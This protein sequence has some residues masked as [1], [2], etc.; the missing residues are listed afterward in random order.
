MMAVSARS[1][2][3][4]RKLAHLRGHRFG[5][6][7]SRFR[8]L[9]DA[10][11]IVQILPQDF[12]SI[13]ALPDWIVA[14]GDR[15]EQIGVAAAILQARDAIERELS[16]SR[17]AAIA[18]L[19]GDDLFERLCDAPLPEDIF[20]ASAGR[21]PRPEDFVTMGRALRRAAM[22]APFRDAELSDA[23]SVKARMLCDHAAHVIDGTD[24]DR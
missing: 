6:R 19:V 5:A 1:A 8:S 9:H 7:A 20:S 17:L 3:I 23:D 21:L 10:Q 2:M 11:P 12:A 22:P 13:T 15:Q 14:N 18:A 4:R 16:G 24:S